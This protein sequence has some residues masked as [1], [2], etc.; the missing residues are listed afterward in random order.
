MSRDPRVEPRTG[1]VIE[2]CERWLRVGYISQSIDW[3]MINAE[4]LSRHPTVTTFSY[5]IEQWRH[6]HATA[7]IIH[8]EGE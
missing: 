7:T 2:F 4:E 6:V 3:T 1:D 5:S 8:A